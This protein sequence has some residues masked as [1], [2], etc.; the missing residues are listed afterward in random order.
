MSGR[1][2]TVEGQR[3]TSDVRLAAY[4][5]QRACIVKS[6]GGL[7]P[8]E[9]EGSLLRLQALTL[10]NIR[11]HVLVSCWQFLSHCRWPPLASEVSLVLQARKTMYVHYYQQ[12]ILLCMSSLIAC[13]G[14]FDT[15][16]TACDNTVVQLISYNSRELKPK[17]M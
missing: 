5:Q 17:I 2:G 12:S 13:N 3:R 9:L 15:E 16:I 7:V 4:Q 6:G 11:L 1:P 10:T 14:W 8:P